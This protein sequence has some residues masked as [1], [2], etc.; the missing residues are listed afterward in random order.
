MTECITSETEKE[1]VAVG[2]AMMSIASVVDTYYELWMSELV[3]LLRRKN[4]SVYKGVVSILHRGG[5]THA[6]VGNV[7]AAF[8]RARK[9]REVKYG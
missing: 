2:E 1:V 4:K 6:N 3:P 9:S 5:Y 7:G 8:R